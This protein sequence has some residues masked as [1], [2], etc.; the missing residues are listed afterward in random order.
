MDPQRLRRKAVE[1]GLVPADKP[2]TDAECFDLVFLPGFSMA[3]KVTD[4]S[5]RGVGMD[6]VRRQVRNANGAVQIQSTPGKGT[7]FTIRLPLT[8]AIMDT[9]L[10]RVGAERFLIPVSAVVSMLRPA[11]GQV[12]SLLTHGRVLNVRGCELPVIN[13]GGFFGIDGHATDPLQSL[14]LVVENRG[15]DFALQVDE[16]LGQRQVVI[17]P[18]DHAL[19]H[20]PG[21][22]GSAILGD[23]HVALILNPARLLAGSASDDPVNPSSGN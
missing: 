18:F 12:E 4:V 16:V 3:A 11:E 15:K 17:K 20:H 7:V 5:G 6:V 8:T 1:K 21:V 22:S 2:M 19:A 14:L 13:L 23:G 10:L 9:M